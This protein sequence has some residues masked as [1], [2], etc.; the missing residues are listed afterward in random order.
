MPSSEVASRREQETRQSS[1]IFQKRGKGSELLWMV[2]RSR[3]DVR[4]HTR[5]FLTLA[6]TKNNKFLKE[7]RYPG[8]SSVG[9]TLGLG[10]RGRE[11]ES[12]QPD[13]NYADVVEL[14]DTQDLMK[15]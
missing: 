4:Q 5:F 15:I 7:V 12:R 9:R 11:F 3:S 14:V 1:T 13:K 10:P 8:C 2:R 6:R